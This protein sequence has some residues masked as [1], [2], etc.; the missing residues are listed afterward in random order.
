LDDD[1]SIFQSLVDENAAE[2]REFSSVFWL[3]LR[4]AISEATID[5]KDYHMQSSWVGRSIHVVFMAGGGG[6]LSK[7]EVLV[8]D[9]GGELS[10]LEK[11]AGSGFTGSSIFYAKKT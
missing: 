11:N 4:R 8:G 5:T 7:V 9:C 1:E 3:T 6:L 2:S 10:V